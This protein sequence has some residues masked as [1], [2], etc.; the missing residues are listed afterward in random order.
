MPMDDH[1]FM[2]S[3]VGLPFSKP[4]L[5]DISVPLATSVLKRMPASCRV[6]RS[7]QI[8]N[9]GMTSLSLPEIHAVSWK[10]HIAYIQ[11]IHI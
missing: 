6:C 3:L 5:D 8:P 11:Y 4:Q 7:P 9:D 1:H 2:A 10:K